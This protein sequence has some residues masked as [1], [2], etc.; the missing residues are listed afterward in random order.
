[1][2]ILTIFWQHFYI[3]VHII[4]LQVFLYHILVQNVSS[5]FLPLYLMNLVQPMDPTLFFAVFLKEVG[6]HNIP[7]FRFV[8]NKLLSDISIFLCHIYPGPID[9][10]QCYKGHTGQFLHNWYVMVTSILLQYF[11][12]QKSN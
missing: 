1:M 8:F 10:Y 11:H 3:S 9:I 4:G 7:L 6:G 2:C 5:A 12:Y